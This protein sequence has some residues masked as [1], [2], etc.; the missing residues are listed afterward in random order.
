MK[1]VTPRKKRILEKPPA[2]R[3]PEEI[4]DLVYQNFYSLAHGQKLTDGTSVLASRLIREE[5]F[6]REELLAIK[7][8]IKGDEPTAE[9]SGE[10]LGGDDTLAWIESVL[11]PG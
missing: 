1:T 8:I 5:S 2:Y 3:T 4:S 6:G 7:A 11:N 9:L 10:I